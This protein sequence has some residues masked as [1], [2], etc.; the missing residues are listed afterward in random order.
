M[1][2]VSLREWILF[3]TLFPTVIVGVLLAILF[4]TDRTNDLKSGIEEKS[5]IIAE[6]ISQ[7]T[8]HA[9]EIENFQGVNL[10]TNLLHNDNSNII[11]TIF[12]YDADNKSILSNDKKQSLALLN[13]LNDLNDLKSERKIASV[14]SDNQVKSALE[15]TFINDFSCSINKPKL[16][17]C[18]LNDACRIANKQVTAILFLRQQ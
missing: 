18:L 4:A 6:A 10:F 5:N 9:I 12:I 8:A 16:N 15:I 14:K 13:T 17:S 2:K 1:N 11:R 7:S 3:L